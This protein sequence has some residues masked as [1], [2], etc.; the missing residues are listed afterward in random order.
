MWLSW[1][2]RLDTVLREHIDREQDMYVGARG[3]CES[4]HE[5]LGGKGAN[6]NL[7]TPSDFAQMLGS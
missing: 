1:P 3:D 5:M 2:D 6:V 7:R 4:S